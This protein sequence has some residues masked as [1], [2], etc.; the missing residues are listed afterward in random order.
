MFVILTLSIFIAGGT[1]FWG[2]IESGRFY[3][4][5]GGVYTEVSRLGY[6]LS[7]IG[8]FIVGLSFPFAAYAGFSI[9]GKI[10]DTK[11]PGKKFQ[12]FFIVFSAFVGGDLAL[13][14]LIDFILAI[15]TVN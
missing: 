4:G 10:K 3:L 15:L 1:A 12:I 2:K 9:E 14:S 5:E 8:S 13:S 6:I 7:S 11:K